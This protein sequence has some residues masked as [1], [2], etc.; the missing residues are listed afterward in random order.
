MEFERNGQ[1][2][3]S[4]YADAKSIAQRDPAAK[5]IWQV[6]L[7][8]PGFHI[9]IYHKLAHWCYRHHFFFI[10][11]L[12]SQIGRFWTLI[13]IHP[14]AQIG[15]GLFIDHGAGVVIGETA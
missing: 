15:Q 2:L 4:L 10:A 13:E 11:R 6:I 14:G 7:L 12:I 3:M 5:G 9:L 1:L 8:Y